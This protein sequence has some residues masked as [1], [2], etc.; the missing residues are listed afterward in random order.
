MA[1]KACLPRRQFVAM[2]SHSSGTVLLHSAK[3][4]CRCIST[5]K[6]SCLF[7]SRT[8]ALTREFNCHCSE[9]NLLLS[10]QNLCMKFSS[11]CGIKFSVALCHFLFAETLKRC[12][13]AML[14]SACSNTLFSNTALKSSLELLILHFETVVNIFAQSLQSLCA[15]KGNKNSDAFSVFLVQ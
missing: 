2:G 11:D 4:F 8:D 5:G 6:K 13:T 10:W 7:T 9:S 3:S 15:S 12:R 14:P 1:D